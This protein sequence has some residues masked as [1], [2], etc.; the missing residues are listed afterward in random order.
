MREAIVLGITHTTVLTLMGLMFTYIAL[1]VSPRRAFPI[2]GVG[3]FIKMVVG[4]GMISITC[5]SMSES[6]SMIPYVLTVGGGVCVSYP[7]TAVVL[8]SML[9]CGNYVKMEDRG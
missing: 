9:R 2:Y 1:K 4:I 7:C 6:G 5:L 8:T 3:M